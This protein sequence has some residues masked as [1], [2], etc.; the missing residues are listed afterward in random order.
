[1]LDLKE[2]LEWYVSQSF[3]RTVGSSKLREFSFQ[4]AQLSEH[5]IVLEVRN[6]RGREYVIVVIV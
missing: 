1:M 6:R 4:I 3:G 5:T 2:S